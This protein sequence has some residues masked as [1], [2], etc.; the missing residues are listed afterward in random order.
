MRISAQFWK[1]SLVLELYKKGLYIFVNFE[2]GY[3]V[4]F[5]IDFGI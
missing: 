4:F 3:F 5:Y 1:I 2:K